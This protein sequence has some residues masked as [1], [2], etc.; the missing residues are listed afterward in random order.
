MSILSKDKIKKFILPYLSESKRGE[1]L[2]EEKRISIV[3]AIFHRLKTGCQWRELPIERYF[4][5]GYSPKTVFYHFS[6]WCKDGS[7]ESMWINLLK[8]YKNLLD[9]SSIQLD[10]S[11]TRANR[12]GEKVGFQFRKADES[13]NFLYLCDNQGVLVAIS[14]PISG[15]HHDLSDIK[16]HFH[17]LMTWLEKADIRTEGLFLNA[18]AGRFAAAI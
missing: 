6:K 7:W 4:K 15:E 14:E 2:T 1:S 16:S 3:S 8:Q 12:G 13:T 18:D 17:Y 10:G 11:Q 9:L 5:E